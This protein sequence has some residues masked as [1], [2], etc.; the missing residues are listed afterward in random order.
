MHRHHPIQSSATVLLTLALAM[1]GA[2]FAYGSEDAIRDC[3]SRLRSEYH[4]NDL[5]DATA[6]KIMDSD[7]HYKVRGM[8]KVD[9]D[10]HA[11]SCEVKNRHVTSAEYSGP[12]PKG[13]GTAEKLAVGAA[14]AIAIG[15]AANEASKHSSGTQTG[16]SGSG[17]AGLQ[18]LVGAKGSSGESALESRG[19][20]Y[21]SGSKSGGSSYT[22]WSKGS[23]CVTVKTLNGRYASIVDAPMADCETGTSQ[24]ASHAKHSG[25]GA[26]ALQDLVGA[27]ASS[28]EAE[29]ESRGYE[30]ISTEKG[31]GSAYST[32]LKGSHCVTTRTVDGR[33]RSIV[34][35]TMA[36]CE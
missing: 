22:N 6:E 8:A 16:H 9:G 14:A 21:A 10:K 26:A 30:F 35:V 7:H 24:G 36:D 33:Y 15:V 25:S 3:E 13:M 18:D 11:W 2:A 12:K 32:W 29:L 17:A 19:Y 4:L 5:R 28:G 31:G 1:P 23:H 20:T 34:D 27:R